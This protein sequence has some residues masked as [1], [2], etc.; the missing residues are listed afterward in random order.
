MIISGKY[1]ECKIKKDPVRNMA[2][3]DVGSGVNIIR[4]NVERVEIIN[5]TS[6]SNQ[7]NVMKGAFYAG[8]A[9]A[10]VAS[11]STTEILIM[12]Y[13]V[14]GETSIAKVGKEIFEAITVGMHTN[15]TEQET[16]KL[17]TERTE[18]IEKKKAEDDKAKFWMFIIAIAWFIWMCVSVEM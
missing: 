6:D 13:W 5:S 15:F 9:G 4:Q 12:I 14:D 1:N 18:A 17:N 3:V 7:A 2:Y 8:T 16:D 10:L 11:A